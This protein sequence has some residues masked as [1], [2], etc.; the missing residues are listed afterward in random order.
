VTF[1]QW[2]L[3]HRAFPTET[4]NPGRAFAAMDRLLAVA[5][6]IVEAIH[7]NADVPAHYQLH[8]PN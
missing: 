2:R 3:P 8:C 6:M 1:Y 5:N 4:L 7:Y